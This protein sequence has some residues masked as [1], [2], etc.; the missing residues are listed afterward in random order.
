M[1]FE[2]ELSNTAQLTSV[3]NR[4]RRINSVYD[5]YRVLPGAGDTDR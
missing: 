1:R 5:A 3:I 4:I 2:F